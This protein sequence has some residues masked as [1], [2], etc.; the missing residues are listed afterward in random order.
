MPLVK[1]FVSRLLVWGDYFGSWELWFT[2]IC[3]N[4]LNMLFQGGGQD[5]FHGFDEEEGKWRFG[6]EFGVCEKFGE[7]VQGLG[8]SFGWLHPW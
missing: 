7:L 4:F 2:D 8:D 5:L 3:H 6:G 1:C